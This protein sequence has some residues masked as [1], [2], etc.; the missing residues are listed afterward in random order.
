MRLRRPSCE[1]SNWTSGSRQSAA[2]TLPFVDHR[3]CQERLELQYLAIEREYVRRGRPRF[4][5]AASD[6]QQHRL[7]TLTAR[8]GCYPSHRRRIPSTRAWGCRRME[9]PFPQ[10]ITLPTL[11][12]SNQE[13]TKQARP[14]LE[15][16]RA[17][18]TIRVRTEHSSH[19]RAVQAIAVVTEKDP[20]SFLPPSLLAQAKHG[21]QLSTIE[22]KPV[23]LICRPEIQ[24][25]EPIMR[26]VG[27]PRT[28]VPHLARTRPDDRDSA[29]TRATDPT[30]ALRSPRAS[31]HRPPGR[32]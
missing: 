3:G 30:R 14:A 26:H 16:G 19:Y 22:P 11:P 15:P 5:G 32:A 1:F 29:P 13:L 23:P 31:R 9:M 12:R 8:A 10:V 25:H 27:L 18:S 4:W 2:L 21:F 6:D 24:R 20:A 7:R 17:R 28:A